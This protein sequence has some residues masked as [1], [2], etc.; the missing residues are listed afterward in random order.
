MET[1]KNIKFYN[2]F[3]ILLLIISCSSKKDYTC[4]CDIS[5]EKSTSAVFMQV[6]EEQI[7]KQCD[8]FYKGYP[9]ATASCKS[10]AN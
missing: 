10:E 6:T 1:L 9:A 5:G 4:F 3:V 7:K 8:E 2:F